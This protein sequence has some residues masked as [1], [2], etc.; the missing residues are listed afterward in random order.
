MVILVTYLCH[1][2]TPGRVARLT[3]EF[4]IDPATLARWR[5]WWRDD[6]PATRFWR[7]HRATFFTL[8]QGGQEPL[9]FLIDHYLHGPEPG[10]PAHE[11]VQALLS[12]FAPLS[13]FAPAL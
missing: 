4:D 12:F 13:T 7:Q 2:A 1:G 3:Q 5:R 9:V 6:F 11:E 10:P 8:G